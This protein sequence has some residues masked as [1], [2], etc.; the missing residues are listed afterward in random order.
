MLEKQLVGKDFLVGE[1]SI[2]DIAS[3]SWVH[4]CEWSGISL[5]GLPNVQRWMAHLSSRPAVK[6]GLDIPERQEDWKKGLVASVESVRVMLS[7]TPAP[8][9]K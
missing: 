9:T 2:A 1:Y 6:K 8:N 3:Y 5:D 7:N 4:V